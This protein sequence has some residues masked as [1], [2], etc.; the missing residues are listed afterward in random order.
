MIIFSKDF[1][2]NW[3]GPEVADIALRD[4]GF[5]L[6]RIYKSAILDGCADV[7]VKNDLEKY[8]LEVSR[9]F[10]SSGYFDNHDVDRGALRNDEIY[11][12]S[13]YLDSLTADIDEFAEHP[14][15]MILNK[16]YSIFLIKLESDIDIRNKFLYTIKN[17]INIEILKHS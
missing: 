3:N 1:C 7:N 6:H 17:Q 4:N 16:L 15:Q 13:E 9:E 14:Y 2:K 10:L 5:E 11:Y 12:R 8:F